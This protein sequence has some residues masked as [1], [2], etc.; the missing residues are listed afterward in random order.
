MVPVVK[1]VSGHH[2]TPS[3]GLASRRKTW[4][5]P[6]VTVDS[7]RLWTRGGGPDCA[8]AAVEA[9]RRIALASASRRMYMLP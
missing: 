9:A 4:R 2:A 8:V 5:P 3:P 7:V 1:A 6:S